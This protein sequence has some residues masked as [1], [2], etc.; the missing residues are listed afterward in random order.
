MAPGYRGMRAIRAFVALSAGFVVLAIPGSATAAPVLDADCPGPDNALAP[1]SV[2]NAQTFAAQTTGT[3][4]QGQIEIL[5]TDS[6]GN[7]TM[8]L[9]ATDGVGAPTNNELASTVIADASVPLGSSTLTGVF[10]SP[11]SVVAGQGYALGIS[12]SPPV[13]HVILGRRPASCLGDEFFSDSAS[14]AWMI[15]VRNLDYVFATYVEPPPPPEP[16]DSNAPNV[17]I[18]SGPKAK[19]KKKT[20]TFT[21]TGTDARA[22]AS[23]QC[24]VDSAAFEPCT[25]P[26]TVK[27]K[28]GKHTFEVQAIDQAGNVG[29]PATDDWKVKKKRKK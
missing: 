7:F 27:V 20:A 5:K 10:P 16:L 24:K 26:H 28:N 11:P 22:V 2:R 14:G 8:T 13:S 6:G 21:F 9:Y 12:Q 4:V 1:A 18:T 15:S 17:T 23:F 3:L 25:S 19:T 29:A